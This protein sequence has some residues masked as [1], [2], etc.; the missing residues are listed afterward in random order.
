[1]LIVHVCSLWYYTRGCIHVQLTSLTSWRWADDARNMWGNLILRNLYKKLCIK[2]V[3]IKELY[4]NARPT[5]SQHNVY[6]FTTYWWRTIC[7][8]CLYNITSLWWWLRQT[9]KTYG[10]AKTKHYAVLGNN[11]TCMLQIFWYYFLN[12]CLIQENLWMLIHSE[13]VSPNTSAW[14]NLNITF[15][16][17]VV[18]YIT[19][20]KYLIK[21]K[22]VNTLIYDLCTHSLHTIDISVKLFDCYTT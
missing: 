8:L 6:M 19:S 5:K 9:A 7:C 12:V 20:K 13:P 17:G 21:I 4:Y 10:S 14:L 15:L 2:L 18:L 1:M 22:K 3:S 16:W 11:T